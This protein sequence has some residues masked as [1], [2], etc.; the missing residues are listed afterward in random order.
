MGLTSGLVCALLW[1]ED[2]CIKWRAEIR[3]LVTLL[4]QVQMKLTLQKREMGSRTPNQER[5]RTDSRWNILMAMKSAK[6]A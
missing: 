4:T 5:K 3:T 2:R 6:A 1:P